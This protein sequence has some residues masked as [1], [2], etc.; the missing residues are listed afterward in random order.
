[1]A[2]QVANVDAAATL[3]KSRNIKTVVEPRSLGM[4]R[5]AF[6]EDSNGVRIEIVEQ[7]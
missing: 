2:I 5:Y 3:F 4:L 7:H 6:F 1:M